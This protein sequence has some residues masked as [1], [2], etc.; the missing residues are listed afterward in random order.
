MTVAFED[1]TNTRIPFT[2][3][4]KLV[5]RA[6]VRATGL[7]SVNVPIVHESKQQIVG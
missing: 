1:S 6:S 7:L 2:D 5:F 4:G 3:R